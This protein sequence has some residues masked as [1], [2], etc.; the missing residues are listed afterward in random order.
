MNW[1]KIRD[2]LSINIFPGLPSFPSL[3]MLMLAS[4]RSWKHSFL[5]QLA[6]CVAAGMG[7]E[8]SLITCM[9][10]GPSTARRVARRLVSS[11]EEGLPLSEA[12]MRNAP[13]VFPKS[14]YVMIGIGERAGTLCEILKLLE[15]WYEDAG[16][17]RMRILTA[18]IYP[19]TVL[20][21][22]AGI[23]SFL[24]VKVVPTFAEIFA[25][26]GGT[27][28][29]ATQATLSLSHLLVSNHRLFLS[30]L[31][32]SLVALLLFVKFAPR[33]DLLGRITL[34][35][36][37]VG[38]LVYHR[39]LL[40]FSSLMSMLLGAG[41]PAPE[42][43]SLC[44]PETMYPPLRDAVKLATAEVWEGRALSEAISG[45]R[46]FSPTFSWLVSV[47]EQKGSLADSFEAIAEI[48]KSRIDNI[49]EIVRYYFEPSLLLLMSLAVGFLVVAMWLPI[50]GIS[51]LI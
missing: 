49:V 35:I 22:C 20:A 10:G 17:T 33:I 4:G 18:L 50:L 44:E 1:N 41:M 24:L 51:E 14:F 36:P 16:S 43:L 39:D 45:K 34:K 42:A 15:R 21:T 3:S 19:F 25:D 23:I 30:L 2:I 27:L 28:P 5:H 26:M 46:V 11:L 38:R 12:L 32:V 9:K 8:D 47:G 40:R 7:L 6:S 29:A 13:K 48:E 37:L 31:P